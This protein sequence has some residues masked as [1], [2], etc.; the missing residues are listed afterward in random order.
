VGREAVIAAVFEV[1]AHPGDPGVV[2]HGQRRIG[3]SSILQHLVDAIPEQT[4][5]RALYLDPNERSAAPLAT[6]LGELAASLAVVLG[7]PVPEPEADVEAWL[8]DR[9]LPAALGSLPP[10]AGLVLLVDEPDVVEHPQ[11]GQVVTALH[12]YLRRLLKKHAPRLR[13]VLALGRSVDD[14][15]NVALALFE[16]LPVCKVSLLARPDA[17]ALARASGPG[18]ARAWSDDAVDA[19]WA[20]TSGHPLLL[21]ALA[22][23]VRAQGQAD[24]PVSPADVQAAVEPTLSRNRSAFEW[25]WK[26]LP[27]AARAALAGLASA[28][29]DGMTRDALFG[30]L[31]ANGA[32]EILRPLHDAPRLLVEQEVA[33]EPAPGRYRFRV[34]LL[35][36]LVARYKPPAY[37]QQDIDLIE[38]AA[39]ELCR[40][41][42]GAFRKGD[43]SAARA[44]LR[45]ALEKNPNHARAM[46]LLTDILI[47]RKDWAGARPVVERL[48]ESK[49]L[50]SRPRL[51]KVLLAQAE[52]APGPEAQR[53]LYERI[54][55]LDPANPIAAAAIERLPSL[56]PPAAEGPRPEP[57]RGR[58]AGVAVPAPRSVPPGPDPAALER[59]LEA[60]KR[61]LAAER[62]ALD[63]EK[64]AR[65]GAEARAAALG[66]ERDQ[67]LAEARASKA[68]ITRLA[69]ASAEAESAGRALAAEKRTRAAA[70]S[71][72]SALGAE[73][74]RLLARLREEHTPAVSMGPDPAVLERALAA[75]KRA[76]VDAEA[77]MAGLA[78]E[79]D[80]LVA[81][82]RADQAERVRA[83]QEIQTLALERDQLSAELSSAQ[84]QLSSMRV[85]LTVVPMDH[86]PSYPPPRGAPPAVPAPPAPPPAP[87][88][89]SAPPPAPSV[90]PP[91][92]SAPP[93]P[94]PVRAASPPPRRHGLANPIGLL[95]GGVVGLGLAY[96]MEPQRLELSTGSLALTDRGD[97]Q[98]VLV[99]QVLRLGGRKPGG[100]VT[101]STS[102]PRVATV[103][104]DGTMRPV[105]TG[106]ARVEARAGRRVASLEVQVSLPAR[107]RVEP[108]E[109]VLSPDTGAVPLTASI[110]DGAGAPWA[111]GGTVTW[112][113]SDP[114]V[115]AVAA[116]K[117][118]RAG[119]GK[120]TIEAHFG[121]LTGV[122]SVLS[123]DRR[124]AL[125]RSCDAADLGACVALG[126][127]VEQGD[128]AR[129]AAA[130]AALAL[131]D[132][133]C[134][135]GVM[136]GCAE[137]GAWHEQGKGGAPDLA[138]A[139]QA[140]QKAC[141]AKDGLG[142]SRLGSMH[143]SGWGVMRD[144]GKALALQRAACDA[145]ELLGCYRLGSMFEV[146]TGVARDAP[147]AADLYRRACD[148]GRPEAC[149]SLANMYWN[150]SGTVAKDVPAGLALYEKACDLRHEPACTAV[151]LKY[152]SGEGVP[153]DRERSL[154]YFAKACAAGSKS[155]CMIAPKPA[156]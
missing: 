30:V 124:D 43:L 93:P 59:A 135:G 119:P 117:A 103:D 64:R 79:R 17:A 99:T 115:A 23:N 92:P 149:G 55:K 127:L 144:L 34:E 2:L 9:W 63:A 151:A 137:A 37:A 94:A 47:Q 69:A 131:Y 67:L 10:E 27:P 32:R 102:D 65:A 13:L 142:C 138:R 50:L 154:G 24:R 114:T 100:A 104:P 12:P 88:F 109:I 130:A 98:K 51:V 19:A 133:A 53:E 56:R 134:D 26:G 36:R 118:E 89:G 52:A 139:A 136:K 25:I 111:R 14:L 143:E 42:E 105:G 97:A 113:S 66:A 22:A 110:L 101:W 44:G 90:P 28:G 45:E 112:R 49:P 8:C 48:H 126:K 91:S 87:P 96:G 129:P 61:A 1:L 40:A 33:V 153:A 35:R 73:R 156:P 7:A 62:A 5:H 60:E 146:G 29:A 76:R 86:Q 140:Y 122:A 18:E 150:G 106:R 31:Q 11:E 41:A 58:E 148:G 81:E 116:G 145:G 125:E 3:K 46:D 155:A 57:P 68:E 121:D 72:A 6:L 15:E 71:R 16:G 20:L 152:K 74:D 141:D 128:E 38:P 95:A 132:R 4:E 85:S 123:L 84:A 80:R 54:K 78:A 21:P 77:R 147:A 39:E 83:G 82:S 75:E 108:A 120:T 70:E 107:I